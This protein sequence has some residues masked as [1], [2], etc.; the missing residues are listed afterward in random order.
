[1]KVATILFLLWIVVFAMWAMKQMSEH[2]R[3]IEKK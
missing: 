2:N 3:R 1:M